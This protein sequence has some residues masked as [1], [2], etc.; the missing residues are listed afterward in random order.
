MS[1]F[2][3]LKYS[4]TFLND[5]HTFCAK[6]VTIL[7]KN[8]WAIKSKRNEIKYI[9]LNLNRLWKINNQSDLVAKWQLFT[10]SLGP[11]PIWVKWMDLKVCPSIQAE[12]ALSYIR[13]TTCILYTWF[14]Y[15]NFWN[16]LFYEP[17][18]PC[19]PFL[20]P[21]QL[22]TANRFGLIVFWPHSF[23]HIFYFP[24]ECSS[25]NK[26]LLC[27]CSFLSTTTVYTIN[28]FQ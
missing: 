19:Q 10:R 6:T 22:I 1:V 12:Y 24:A 7:E 16:I 14:P 11:S 9:N 3:C 5:W 20:Y 4:N 2:L 13:S 17:Y 27:V 8:H 23:P 26:G 21:I 18:N 15:I 28:L 25:W